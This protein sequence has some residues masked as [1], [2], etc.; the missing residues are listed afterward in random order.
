M[1]HILQEQWFL[2][3]DKPFQELIGTAIRLC[4]REKTL[5]SEFQDYSFIVFPAAKAYEG[6]LKKIFLMLDLIDEKTY[7]GKRFRIGKALNP[8][9]REQSRDQYWLFDDI[10]R[11]CS[12]SVS[13]E[14]WETW[15]SS[16]NR[17]FHYYPNSAHVINLEQAEEHIIQISNSIQSLI[18][19][20]T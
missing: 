5:N 8:D 9:V 10:E 4:E 6:I 17:I 7:Y 1:R 12:T 15:L 16:R 19:C 3:L 13:R 18:E 20:Q 14:L 11:L 2:S